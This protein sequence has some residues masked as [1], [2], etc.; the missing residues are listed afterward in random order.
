MKGRPLTIEQIRE[1]LEIAREFGT[2][3][4]IE[5]LE[6]K[7]LVLEFTTEVRTAKDPASIRAVLR[8]YGL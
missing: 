5:D 4:Q 3:K 1:R 8:K 6:R 2:P 7:L